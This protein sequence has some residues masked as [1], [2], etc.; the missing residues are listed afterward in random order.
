MKVQ[1]VADGEKK[2]HIYPEVAEQKP[3]GGREMCLFLEAQSAS[4]DPGNQVGWRA[5]KLHIS[6]KVESVLF[7]GGCVWSEHRSRW[8]V[9]LAFEERGPTLLLAD[10]CFTARF[11]RF[12]EMLLILMIR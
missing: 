7:L 3:E 6:I 1:N 12:S 5:G 8:C 10:L 4:I 2:T 11:V 9:H